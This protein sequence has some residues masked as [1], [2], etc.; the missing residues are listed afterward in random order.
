MSLSVE[1]N[2]DV[3]AA[4]RRELVAYLQSNE[5]DAAAE[6]R[7]QSLPGG[8]AALARVLYLKTALAGL[9]GGSG[10]VE[11]YLN[12]KREEIEQE[13]LRDEAR[14]AERPCCF[15]D[16]GARAKRTRRGGG[17]GSARD[18]RQHLLRS[19]GKPHR[20]LLCPRPP[21]RHGR[22]RLN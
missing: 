8:E 5:T 6:A 18:A 11:E 15:G 13:R 10:S 3:A 4:I 16:A 14:D 2:Q 17:A 9:T 19:S 22:Y 1:Q 12:W 7:L 20:G 21:G